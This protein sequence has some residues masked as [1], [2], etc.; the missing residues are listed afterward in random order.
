MSNLLIIW[1]LFL[2]QIFVINGLE[3]SNTYIWHLILCGI[4]IICTINYVYLWFIL[5]IVIVL[6]L[7]VYCLIKKLINFNKLHWILHLFGLISLTISLL[8]ISYDIINY[9]VWFECLFFPIILVSLFYTFSNR[10]LFSIY[11]LLI[12]N[13]SSSFLC[14]MLLCITLSTWNLINITIL[15]INNINNNLLFYLLMWI[16]LF[17]MFGIKYP[18]WPFHFWLPELH[19]EV[20]TEMSILLASLLLKAGFFG[21]LKFLLFNALATNV[22]FTGIVETIILL[23]ILCIGL[24]IICINDY[25]KIIAYWSIIHTCVGLLFVWMLDFLVILIL[26]LTNLVHIVSSG[27]LFYIIGLL[28]ECVGIRNFLLLNSNFNS[29]LYVY[30]LFYI[31]LLN[32]DFPFMPLF[33]VEILII[34]IANFGN[35]QVLCVIL[36]SNIIMFISS[37]LVFMWLTSLHLSWLSF[38]IKI[39]I[40]INEFFLICNGLFIIGSLFFSV[41]MV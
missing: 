9:L 29:N 35:Y 1:C 20:Y 22:F 21:I 17:I 38:I 15:Y 5:F 23:G 18:I 30:I 2:I 14:I 12:F 26:I 24:L 3:L 34:W 19:V 32:V 31:I 37:F 40:G 11:Y 13:A 39:S 10:F 25:K 4:K 27:Y 41:N 28:Y 36:W 33:I 7:I 8:I 6:N 16:T